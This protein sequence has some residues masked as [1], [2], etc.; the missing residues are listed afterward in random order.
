MGGE[1]RYPTYKEVR[2][3]TTG[4]AE[5]LQVVYDPTEIDYE[6]LVNFFFRMH[7]PTTLYRQKRDRGI[8]YR[9][10]IFFHS[11]QQEEIAKRVMTE[12]QEKHYKHKP[13]V[14]EITEA[15]EFWTAEE[16]HQDYLH[17]HPNGYCNH[18]LYW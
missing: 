10:V 15:Q 2:K 12:I 14:T 6:D 4:H 7:D 11:K 9:S 8:H 3:S 5:V 1:L 13:I 17:K 18:E 16:E